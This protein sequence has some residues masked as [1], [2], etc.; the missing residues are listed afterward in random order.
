MCDRIDDK[1]SLIKLEFSKKQALG[2]N[3]K[4]RNSEKERIYLRIGAFEPLISRGGQHKCNILTCQLNLLFFNRSE[5]ETSVSKCL[6]LKYKVFAC[7]FEI[8]F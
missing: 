7:F 1:I 2:K 5:D 4:D 3:G 6:L 8:I